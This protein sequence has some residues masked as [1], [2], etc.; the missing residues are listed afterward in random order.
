MARKQRRTDIQ[1]VFR[2]SHYINGGEVRQ[3][4]N[5]VDEEEA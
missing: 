3:P 5:S 2:R 1:M 4:G